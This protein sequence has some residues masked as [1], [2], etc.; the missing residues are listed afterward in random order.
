MGWRGCIVSASCVLAAGLI[1]GCAPT[2]AGAECALSP[3][4]VSSALGTTVSTVVRAP[5]GTGSDS[6]FIC[7]YGDA[8]N[9][10][11]VD[12]SWWP[13][14]VAIGNEAE[15]P[16]GTRHPKPASS[17]GL[18]HRILHQ[19]RRR[20]SILGRHLRIHDLDLRRLAARSF[21]AGAARRNSPHSSRHP[22]FAWVAGPTLWLAR[23]RPY[24]FRARAVGRP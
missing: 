4:E 20:Y 23:A 2:A 17:L 14:G 8:S 7:S 5:A 3:Q 21:D 11:V 10:R 24:R 18:A 9:P 13:G 22:A 15:D 19:L 16:D 1:A 12:L 6:G